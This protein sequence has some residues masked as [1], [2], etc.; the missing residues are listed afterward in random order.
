LALHR[1]NLR[2]QRITAEA[3][4]LASSPARSPE[5]CRDLALYE[6]SIRDLIGDLISQPNFDVA[7]DRSY[8]ADLGRS[9]RS[10][11]VEI[12]VSIAIDRSPM[13]L[14]TLM[15]ILEREIGE[16][17]S[18]RSELARMMA[19]RAATDE[20][21]ARSRASTGAEARPTSGR[22]SAARAGSRR[23]TRGT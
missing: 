14:S 18:A 15:D 10:A 19:E 16:S 8:A 12:V 4:T 21:P 9:V 13:E 1:Q 17:P 3:A 5:I 6:I 22:K 2:R 23:G 11:I 20:S 7:A